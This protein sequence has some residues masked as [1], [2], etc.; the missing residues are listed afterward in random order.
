MGAAPMFPPGG[1]CP[2]R[3]LGYGAMRDRRFCYDAFCLPDNFHGAVSSKHTLMWESPGRQVLWQESK[4]GMDRQMELRFR[5]A[6]RS[7]VEPFGLK[8]SNRTGLLRQPTTVRKAGP[9]AE[10]TRSHHA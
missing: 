6:V 2:Q 7:V 9:T 8:V 5:G 4:R 1:F 3:P 10:P